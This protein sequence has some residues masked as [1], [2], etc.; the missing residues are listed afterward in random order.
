[1]NLGFQTHLMNG[2]ACKGKWSAIFGHIKRI[3]DYMA[4]IGGILGHEHCKH[5]FF[6]LSQG[7]LGKTCMT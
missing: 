3:Y 5:N 2:L 7:A 4:S 1:M 6:Q